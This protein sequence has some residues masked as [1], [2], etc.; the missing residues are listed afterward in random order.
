VCLGDAFVYGGSEMTP[1][2]FSTYIQSFNMSGFWQ[3]HEY[4]LGA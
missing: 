2:S 3:F 1:Q 4:F